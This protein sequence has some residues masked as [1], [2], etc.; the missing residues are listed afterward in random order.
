[1]CPS[2]LCRRAVHRLSCRYVPW[3]FRRRWRIICTITRACMTTSNIARL[4]APRLRD[5]FRISSRRPGGQS[6]FSVA[7]STQL[8]DRKPLRDLAAWML[9]NLSRPLT[10][11]VLAQQVAMSPRNFSRTFTR[12]MQVTP[13][14][15]VERL[16]VEIVRRRLEETRHSLKRIAGDC[17]FGSV[18]S[19]REVFQRAVRIAPGDYRQRFSE[20]P[21]S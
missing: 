19:M 11:Q 9:E 8:S 20:W 4:A 7:L 13:A 6:Q 14:K 1:M 18:K 16:R 10:V 15:Y 21:K 5:L 17:G 2:A 3:V 12:E